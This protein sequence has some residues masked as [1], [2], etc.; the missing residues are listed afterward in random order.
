MTLR[1]LSRL[2]IYIITPC[3]ILNAFQIDVTQEVRSDVMFDF[4]MAVF[5]QVG[6]ITAGELLKRFAHFSKMQQ[7]HITH[8]FE[9]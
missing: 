9:Y 4:G 2:S 8:H 1:A 5:L 3:T 6:M 7:W